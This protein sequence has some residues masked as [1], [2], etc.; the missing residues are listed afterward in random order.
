MLNDNELKTCLF[1]LELLLH[2][3]ASEAKVVESQGSAM[4]RI[5]LYGSADPAF[6]NLSQEWFN[7]YLVESLCT[8]Y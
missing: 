3:V 7:L 4:M 6:K 2:L 1:H 8:L 5:V